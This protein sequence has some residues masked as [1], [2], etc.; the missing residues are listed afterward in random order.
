MCK[1]L[2]VGFAA[3]VQGN[4]EGDLGLIGLVR[5]NGCT[6]CNKMRVPGV[7]GVHIGTW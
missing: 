6:D 3:W 7:V 1:L 4:R 5:W 2:G